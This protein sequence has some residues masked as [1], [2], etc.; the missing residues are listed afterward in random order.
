M[1][2]KNKI[3]NLLNIY[4]KEDIK[5]E[6]YKKNILKVFKFSKKNFNILTP[7][8]FFFI[9]K[10]IDLND[11]DIL[12]SI[13]KLVGVKIFNNFPHN[14][15]LS[16]YNNRRPNEYINNKYFSFDFYL[17]KSDLIIKNKYKKMD[18]Y[19]LNISNFLSENTFLINNIFKT[20]RKSVLKNLVNKIKGIRSNMSSGSKL[21]IDFFDSS[22]DLF[23]KDKSED[24]CQK[25]SEND[26]I[27]EENNEKKKINKKKNKKPIK[28]KKKIKKRNDLY[29]L[30]LV[31][32]IAFKYKRAGDKR[33]LNIFNFIKSRKFYLKMGLSMID[34]LYKIIYKKYKIL[35][36]IKY[37]LYNYLSNISDISYFKF[38][39]L[40]LKY[41]SNMDWVFNYINYDFYNKNF[42]EKLENFINIKKFEIKDI[43]ENYFTKF[44]NFFKI[45]V[46]IKINKIKIDIIRNNIIKSKLRFS[47]NLTRK[48]YFNDLYNDLI[49]ETRLSL[50]KSINEYD[51][52]LCD[53]I[54]IFIS[55]NSK[56]LIGKY[57][58][59]DSRLIRLPENVIY[60]FR[61]IT[62]V[63]K[64]H[65]YKYNVNPSLKQISSILNIKKK[66]IN[67]I[68]SLCKSPLS[69]NKLSDDNKY[70]FEEFLKDS[71]GLDFD[72]EIFKSELKS[73][74]EEISFNLNNNRSSNIINMRYGLDFS[75][76]YTLAEVGELY[77]LSRERI[78]QIQKKVLEDI[79][80]IHPEIR[81]RY[82]FKSADKLYKI[83]K[84]GL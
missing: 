81:L 75:R 5:F 79:K 24:I 36:K 62:E 78:R 18:E 55:Y 48:Y 72:E 6:I 49:Q 57:I 22:N 74:V 52:N 38:S 42:K 35:N 21:K 68:L 83:N 19:L 69:I 31:S 11:I 64:K 40:F 53:N 17:K 15:I 7:D 29:F 20:K 67:T 77:S 65:N 70:D 46:F 25:N 47:D 34:Y 66:R 3:I 61:K 82:F 27:D 63:I 43:E 23:F 39:F 54:N 45:F 56:R 30:N 60:S 8:Y 50:I 14:Y 41:G 26:E 44:K 2:K 84:K 80:L 12:V 32:E 1:K 76:R 73:Y 16:I 37:S 71:K 4:F 28:K 51:F 9:F 59:S 10:E 13:M 33:Y 58:Y